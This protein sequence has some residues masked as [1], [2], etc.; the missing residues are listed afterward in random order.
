MSHKMSG[1]E[2]G[3]EF[4]TDCWHHLRRTWLREQRCG[5]TPCVFV[6]VFTS[7][8][9]KS[10][11]NLPAPIDSSSVLNLGFCASARMHVSYCTY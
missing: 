6:H 2:R 4:L 8:C 7:L 3:G 5:E 11:Q 1:E 9:S 10:N